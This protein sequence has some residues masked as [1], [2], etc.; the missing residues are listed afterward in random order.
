MKSYKEH[1]CVYAFEILNTVFSLKIH[2]P[3]NMNRDD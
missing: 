1:K 2:T 3:N